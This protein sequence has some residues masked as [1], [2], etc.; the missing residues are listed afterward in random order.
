MIETYNEQIFKWERRENQDADVDDFV[1]SDNE[2]IGWSSGLKLKLKSGQVA[3]FS[4][5]QIRA[6]LYRP[7]TKSNLYF[8]RMI[9]ERVYVFPSI[10]PTA[11]N[12]KGES[13]NL[14]CW[15]WR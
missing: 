8:D 3:D 9:T 6:S 5:E 12:R 13:G 11:R 4:R 10:F 1:A 15:Y 7:F 2:K 14:C